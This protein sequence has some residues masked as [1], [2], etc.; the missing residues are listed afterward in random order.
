LR[1]S[2]NRLYGLVVEQL[3]G[4]PLSG[5]LF[6]FTKGHRDRIKAGSLVPAKTKFNNGASTWS[7]PSAEL[8][9]S[10]SIPE[11]LKS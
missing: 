3:K 5:H 7:P 4:D 2:F 1:S 8:I 6:V 11:G 10:G 9:S